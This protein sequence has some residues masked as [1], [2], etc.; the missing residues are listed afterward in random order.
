VKKLLINIGMQS[1]GKEA[2]VT[3]GNET[4]LSISRVEVIRFITEK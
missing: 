1:M 4:T 2:F 3:Y